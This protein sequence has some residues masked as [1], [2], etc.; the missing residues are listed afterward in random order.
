MANNKWA[1]SWTPPLEA[2]SPQPLYLKIVDAMIADIQN[3]TLKTG[4]KLPPVRPLS[5]VLGCNM[6]TVYKA[7]QEAQKRGF[8][9]GETGRGSFVKA[10]RETKEV[11]WPNEAPQTR[12]IDFSDN[13]P[14]A[15]GAIERMI[16]EELK[17]LAEF[18][19]I[20]SLLQYQYN[21]EVPYQTEMAEKHLKSIGCPTGE[22]R[23]TILTNGALHAGFIALMALTSPGD[24]VLTEE[25]T[26]Q[27]VRGAL[28]KLNLRNKGV[29][30]DKDGIIPEEL[31]KLLDQN[32]VK[33]AYFVPTLH[34]P[35]TT[36]LPLKRKEEVAR[37]LKEK[38]VFL[39]EDDVFS[40]FVKTPLPPISAFMQTHAFHTTSLSKLVAPALR[41]GY[42]NLPAAYYEKALSALRTTSWMA[43]PLL[44]QVASVLIDSGKI[45]DIALKRRKE[46]EKR[47]K[48]ALDIL[49][50]FS[51]QTQPQSL[52]LWLHLPEP[53]R[54]GMFAAE[55]RKRDVAVTPTEH[56][57]VE[58][59]NTTHAVRL[60]LGTP[61]SLPL[62]REG[63]EI[64][65]ET[66]R[67]W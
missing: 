61:S 30:M 16:S 10:S 57:A 53:I 43:S 59:S 4:E 24:L 51:Y 44:G 8:I 56:F 1:V 52:H 20:S 39:I 41:I 45:K 7:Y 22:N 11:Y 60:C 31:E 25:F 34:N 33:A 49:S 18:P 48:I 21:S 12:I 9:S 36:I 13:F 29:P 47:Q 19:Y 66:I 3:G 32:N 55:L 6:G 40:S 2:E 46:V 67:H 62:L 38:N 17:Q 37:I 58:R 26:S 5:Y 15:I 42:L 27:A 65:A 14:T 50:G 28:T 64:V 54:A 23:K 63:L 35:T